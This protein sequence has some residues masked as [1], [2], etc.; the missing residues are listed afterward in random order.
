MIGVKRR[1]RADPA[2]P[3]GSLSGIYKKGLNPRKRDK[4]Y[5]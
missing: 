2:R 5:K 4:P 1:M 3:P